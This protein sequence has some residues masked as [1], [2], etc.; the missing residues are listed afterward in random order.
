MPSSEK[1]TISDIEA[2]FASCPR[3]DVL[4]DAGD[5]PESLEHQRMWDSRTKDNLALDDVFVD[6]TYPYNA[7]STPALMH[8]FPAIARLALTSDSCIVDGEWCGVPLVRSI[9]GKEPNDFMRSCDATQKRA[10]I[11]LISHVLHALRH[12]PDLACEEE[13][14][15]AMDRV[16]ESW[17]A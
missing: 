16:L 15:L 7:L 3:P 2:A 17:K 13:D 14:I 5:D 9:L 6:G 4:V 8:F 10:V 1:D 11:G 12:G